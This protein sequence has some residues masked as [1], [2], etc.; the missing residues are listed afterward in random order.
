[1]AGTVAGRV[2]LG[3]GV[4]PKVSP[5]CTGAVEG[6]ARL[7]C[8]GIAAVRA[9]LGWGARTTAGLAALA[10]GRLTLASISTGFGS[11]LGSGLGMLILAVSSFS[12]TL[13][14]SG[15]VILGGSGSL[16]L[17][18]GGGVVGRINTVSSY[19][20]WTS[21]LTWEARK[22]AI[23]TIRALMTRLVKN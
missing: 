18:G 23:E 19:L 1:M 9:A 6:L 20:C 11:G 13:G 22:I 4:T 5:R 3:L 21:F 17:G 15:G 10:A 12:S 2:A 8:A 7:F 16:T 14:G